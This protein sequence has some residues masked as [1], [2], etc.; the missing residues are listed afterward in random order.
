MARR[1]RIPTVPFERTKIETWFERDR[2]YVALVD[3]KTGEYIVEWW[4]EDVH[5]LVEDGFLDPRDW[6]GSAYEYANYL[7]IIRE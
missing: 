6:H 4:D 3:K 2:A 7:G 1:R 5:S